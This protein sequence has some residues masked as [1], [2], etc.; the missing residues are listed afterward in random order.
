MI[1]ATGRIDGRLIVCYAQAPAVRAGVGV[2]ESRAMG[3]TSLFDGGLAQ[4]ASPQS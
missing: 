2:L 4:T 1:A 3:V